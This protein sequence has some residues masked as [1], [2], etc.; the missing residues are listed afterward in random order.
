[1]T[2]AP[3][4]TFA[5]HR[6]V[7][8]MLWVFVTLACMELLAVHLFVA[9]KWPALAWPLSAVTLLSI[10][11]LVRWLLSW[12]HRPHEL[13]ASR[14][15]LHMGSLLHVDVPL[16][17]IGCIRAGISAD[18][19]KARTTRNLVPIA[20]PNRLIELRTPLPDRRATRHIAIRIDDPAAFD[21]RM[22]AAGV[23][24]TS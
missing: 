5:N 11:W 1:M 16:D 22:A 14:L 2:T 7:V 18:L 24:I 15:R 21:A 8:P 6:G 19:L 10:I 12:K 17:A 4:A 13:D 9:V 23:V 3:V 20:Y